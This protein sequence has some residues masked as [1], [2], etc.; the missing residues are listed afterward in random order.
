MSKSSKSHSPN[1]SKNVSPKNSK[2]NS[3][4][5]IKISPKNLTNKLN[6]KDN[7]PNILNMMIVDDTSSREDNQNLHYWYEDHKI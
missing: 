5:N 4:K 6:Q 3:P 2:R 7:K 1:H